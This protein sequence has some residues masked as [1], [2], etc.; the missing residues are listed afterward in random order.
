MTRYFAYGTNMDSAGM[1]RRCPGAVALGRARL[2]GFRLAVTVDG[3]ATIVAGGGGEVVHGVLWRLTPRCRMALDA[4][5]GVDTGLYR[6]RQLPVRFGAKSLTALVYIAPA[7]AG[8]RAVRMAG[9]AASAR[10][11]GLPAPHVARLA[12]LE[13]RR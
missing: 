10:A 8:A 3:H 2:A 7:V 11:C 9:V 13:A 5:E 6:R 1:A 12:R 4:Y